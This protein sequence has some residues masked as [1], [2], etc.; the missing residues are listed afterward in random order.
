MIS[1]LHWH[2]GLF[3]QPHHLQYLQHGLLAEAAQLRSQQ[4]FAHG[5][6]D[7]AL[8]SDALSNFRLR[9]EALRVALP[10]GRLI[11]LGENAEVGD[12]DLKGL[13]SGRGDAFVISLAV[14]VWQPQ[15]AN[16][17]AMGAPYDARVKLLYAPQEVTLMD[18]NTGAN[19]KSVFVR[20]LNA[21]LITDDEDRSDLEVVPLL[22][23]IRSSGQDLGSPRL[24]PEFVPPAVY[25]ESSAL[26]HRKV[27]DLVHFIEAGQRQLR[28]QLNRGGFDVES[29]RGVQFE[30]IL[31]YR[32]LRRMAARLRALLSAPRTSPFTWYLELSE[33]HAELMALRPNKVD[34]E[35][36]AYSHDH[37]FATFHDLDVKIR[38]LLQSASGASFRRVE[39]SPQDGAFAATLGEEHVSGPADYYLAVRS[40]RDP[41]EVIQLVEDVD[42]FKLMPLSLG[43]R[44][45]RGMVLKEERV[46]PLQLPAQPGLTYFRLGRAES[47]RVWQQIQSEKSIV[48]RWTDMATSDFQLALYM[49]VAA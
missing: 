36:P 20:R 8:S 19:P 22:R 4:P 25:L 46:A 9:F 28:A 6:I 49:T 43:S 27:R 37:L 11:V 14:P 48:V 1:P 10:S 12:L 34:A 38:S 5:V 18:E 7:A 23:L 30:Q 40:L 21:R 2:E 15:R 33:L 47:P 44:A 31:R 3:L 35:G 45:V 13:F 29:M 41:R 42:R 17:F 24:D 16:A 26:L 32:S 39:F